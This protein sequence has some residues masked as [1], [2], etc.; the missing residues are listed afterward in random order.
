[1]AQ[2]ARLFRKQVGQSAH[3]HVGEAQSF[4]PPQQLW[5]KRLRQQ[6]ALQGDDALQGTDEPGVDEGALHHGLGRNVTPERRHDGPEAQIVGVQRQPVQGEGAITPVGRI[7]PEQ[8]PATQLQ[9]AD[10]LL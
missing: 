6:P 10:R 5:S 1:M 9:G 7:F 2:L 8:R 4:G 3:L